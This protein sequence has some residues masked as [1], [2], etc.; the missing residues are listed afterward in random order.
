MTTKATPENNQRFRALLARQ[1]VKGSAR[2]SLP[3]AKHT[4]Q[5]KA[6]PN[7]NTISRMFK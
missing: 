7:D 5:H 1:I 3:Y 2:V 4:P 6:W